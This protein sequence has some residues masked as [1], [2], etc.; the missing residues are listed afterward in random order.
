MKPIEKTY[1]RITE[2]DTKIINNKIRKEPI[3]PDFLTI[4]F[5][6]SLNFSI[7]RG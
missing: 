4:K 3:L 5:K 6:V 1:L 7:T 2:I